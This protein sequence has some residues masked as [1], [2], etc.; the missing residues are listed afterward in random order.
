MSK[1]SRNDR[2][3]IV[4]STNGNYSYEYEQGEET[5]ETLPNDKQ[6]LKILLDRKQRKGKEVTLISAFVGQEEDLATLGKSLKQ[7][8]GVG[9][10][11]KD[12]EILIQGDQRQKVIELLTKLGF[13]QIK[14]L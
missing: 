14:S 11:V 10:S 6:R 1:Q 3:G 8:C 5:P 7:G 12:G 13:K 9:G 2:M 4:Y